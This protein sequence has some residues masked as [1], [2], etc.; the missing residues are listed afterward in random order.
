M[1]L[2]TFKILFKSCNSRLWPRLKTSY[3]RVCSLSCDVLLYDHPSD[4]RGFYYSLRPFNY[5]QIPEIA[6]A[7]TPDSKSFL[8]SSCL[9]WMSNK[10]IWSTWTR[11]VILWWQ[12]ICLYAPGANKHRQEEK[13]RDKTK[14]GPHNFTLG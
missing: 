13:K 11:V 6:F 14:P 8:L 1:N 12:I 7:F 9:C 5:D 3:S 2:A 10:R 4:V